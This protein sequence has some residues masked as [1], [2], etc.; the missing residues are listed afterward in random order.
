[1]RQSSLNIALWV[2]L[3]LGLLNSC[4]DNQDSILSKTEKNNIDAYTAVKDYLLV[5]GRPP[6]NKEDFAKFLEWKTEESQFYEKVLNIISSKSLEFTDMDTLCEFSINDTTFTT[7]YNRKDGIYCQGVIC[8]SL[9]YLREKLTEVKGTFIESEADFLKGKNYH[10][11]SPK[12]INPTRDLV[13]IRENEGFVFVQ[14]QDSLLNTL[15]K[16]FTD[17]IPNE[18]LEIGVDS[19]VLMMYMPYYSEFEPPPPPM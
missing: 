8:D 13:F 1:M 17:V 11:K 19:L 3:C 16:N 2:V 18:F 7:N 10:F 6:K 12:W 14:A 4:L 15:Y 9:E 5:N